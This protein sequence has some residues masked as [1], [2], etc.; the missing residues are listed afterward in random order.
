M[1]KGSDSSFVDL[2]VKYAHVTVAKWISLNFRVRYGLVLLYLPVILVGL[3][4]LCATLMNLVLCQVRRPLRRLCF[5]DVIANE[6]I[7]MLE[8]IYPGNGKVV[9]TMISAL[10]SDIRFHGQLTAHEFLKWTQKNPSALTPLLKFQQRM[11]TC[12]GGYDFWLRLS[13]QRARM[14]DPVL[15][16]P[17]CMLKLRGRVR[18][19]KK[20]YQEQRI[21]AAREKIRKQNA[22]NLQLLQTDKNT[23]VLLDKFGVASSRLGTDTPQAGKDSVKSNAIVPDLRASM[24]AVEL[25]KA[26]KA[27][28]NSA[29]SPSKKIKDEKKS[30]SKKEKTPSQNGLQV[31]PREVSRRTNNTLNVPSTSK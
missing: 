14:P 5:N 28:P 26:I 10:N 19:L 30:S 20:L 17:S 24:A 12:F 18:E 9:D 23:N 6:I 27:R 16:S 11:Q 29:K 3:R 2:V 4:S 1:T 25:D 15:R 7:K 22:T 13:Q 21:H 8:L 31:Q